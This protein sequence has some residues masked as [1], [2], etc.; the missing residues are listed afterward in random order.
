MRPV[1]AARR[2]AHEAKTLE[3]QLDAFDASHLEAAWR[4]LIIEFA[5]ERHPRSAPDQRAI[6][7]E[8]TQQG[9]ALWAALAEL[10]L[11][12]GWSRVAAQ[13]SEMVAAEARTRWIDAVQALFSAVDGWWG[14]IVPLLAESAGRRGAFWRRMLR[15][16]A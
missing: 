13:T 3:A 16:S 14:R 15:R 10:S 11:A 2:A 12:A 6:A 7:A 4:T 1:L 5:R 8:L 9:A